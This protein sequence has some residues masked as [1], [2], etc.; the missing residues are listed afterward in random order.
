MNSN[1]NELNTLPEGTSEEKE[2][3]QASADAPA[4]EKKKHTGK[5]TRRKLITLLSVALAVI[6]LVLLLVPGGGLKWI[7]NNTRLMQSAKALKNDVKELAQTVMEQDVPRAEIARQKMQQDT[8]AVRDVLSNPFWKTAGVM[9]VAKNRLNDVKTLLDILEEADEELIGPLL[10]LMGEYPLSELKTDAGINDAAI[11]NYLRFAAEAIPE[12]KTL[13]LRMQPLDLS[14]FDS[15]GTYKKLMDN[16]EE[17]LALLDI[18]EEADETM[19]RPLI[20]LMEDYPLSAIKSES[21]FVNDEALIGYIRL[22]EGFI[23]EA[24]VLVS[25]AGSLDLSGLLNKNKADKISQKFALAAD[26]LDIAAQTDE[27]IIRQLVPVMEKYP[28]SELKQGKDLNVKTILRY[29]DFF[30]DVLPEI[31]DLADSIRSYDFESS[32]TVQKYVDKFEDLV[33]LGNEAVGLLPIARGVL[34]DGSDR[35]LLLVAQNNAEIRSLGGFPGQVGTITIKDGILKLNSFGSSWTLFTKYTPSSANLTAIERRAF[36]GIWIPRDAE[37]CPVFER[38]ALVWAEAYA[39]QNDV[40]VDGVVSATQEVIEKFL[41]FLGSIELSDGTVMNGENAM[42]II[43][44]DLYVTYFSADSPYTTSQANLI[45]DRL[46]N[47]IASKTMDLAISGLKPSNLRNY[48]EAFLDGVNDRSIQIWVRDEEVQQLIRNEGWNSSLNDD[49]ERPEIGVYFSSTG[50][51]SKNSWYLDVDAELSDAK[52]NTDGTRSYELKVTF[53][54]VLTAEEKAVLPEW[55]IGKQ[56]G[57]IGGWVYVFAPAGGSI[58]KY[59]ANTSFNIDY[60]TYK[61]LE[62]YVT[63]DRIKMNKPLVVTCTITTAPGV[64]TVPAIHLP[65]TLT[66]YR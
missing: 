38:V 28:L 35:T 34:G 9:P 7:V 55:I 63:Q 18:A 5:M 47:E 21:S 1:D 33:D 48:Y 11:L 40:E 64:E 15:S 20:A 37:I 65:R 30:E 54:N 12:T 8:A 42:R 46:F 4:G 6:L 49:P 45:T 59:R 44:H 3:F 57:D 56:G 58:S 16:M 43:C 23:P 25:E 29:L 50:G 10:S 66:E 52:I 32:E 13:A 31:N 60:W 14:R 36:Y 26:L 51:G 17:I 24:K 62:C 27:T 2:T 19:L 53:T 41:S 39:K 61:G 22:F